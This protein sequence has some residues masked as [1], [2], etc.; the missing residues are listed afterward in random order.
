MCRLARVR[1]V[2]VWPSRRRGH[3][4]A[5]REP[6][7]Q[8][9]ARRPPS[10]VRVRA[11][12]RSFAAARSAAAR[13]VR[14][15]AGQ[16]PW[17]MS[18]RICSASRV[19]T[20]TRRRPAQRPC[21]LPRRRASQHQPRRCVPACRLQARACKRLARVL[22]LGRTLRPGTTRVGG[23]ER[24]SQHERH[25]RRCSFRGRAS[26]CSHAGA[27]VALAFATLNLSAVR[28]YVLTSRVP[29]ASQAAPS[30]RPDAPRGGE[31]AA[32]G[33]D[34]D[35]DGEDD[36]DGAGGALRPRARPVGPPLELEAPLLPP[37]RAS[38]AA[39]ARRC[40]ALSATSLTAPC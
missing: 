5:G 26:G 32:G 13:G 12:S 9:A 20:T 38:R 19:K 6:A 4:E 31:G 40:A 18:C 29:R 34:D 25:A 3:N 1:R 39:L 28:A 35:A 14:R 33:E 24:F 36:E 16:Q 21:R 23:G 15:R 7:E 30:T 10:S 8:N 17:Q 2:A 37:P 27:P 22:R 11:A